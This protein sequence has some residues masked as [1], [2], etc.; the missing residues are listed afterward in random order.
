MHLSG[1]PPHSPTSHT[2]TLSPVVSTS[3]SLAGTGAGEGWVSYSPGR[4]KGRQIHGSSNSFPPRVPHI[5]SPQE[6]DLLG[7]SL[8]STKALTALMGWD[9]GKTSP[10]ALTY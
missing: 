7:L 9:Q 6:A 10:G 5:P 1:A 8:P 2:E 3:P 4:S